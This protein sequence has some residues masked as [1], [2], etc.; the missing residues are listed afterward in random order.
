V[1]NAGRIR[2]NGPG[3][4]ILAGESTGSDGINGFLNSV[5]AGFERQEAVLGEKIG[6]RPV[7]KRGDKDFER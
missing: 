6:D 4:R 3:E 7:R 2:R 1:S 5:Y